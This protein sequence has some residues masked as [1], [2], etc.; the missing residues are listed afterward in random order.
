MKYFF[1]V[2]EAS[3]DV[4]ASKLLKEILIK[5][6]TAEV[7]FWGGDRMCEVAGADKMLSHY[8]DGAFMG[9]WEVIK[10]LFV[11]LNR[12]S[13]CKKDIIEFAPDVVVLV[14][15]AGFN[16]KIAKFAKSHKI[17]TYY[18][19]APKVWAWNEK[20]TKKI[21]KYVDELFCIFPFEIPFFKKWGIDAHYFGNPIMEEISAMSL[22]VPSYDRFIKDNDLES[23]PIIALLAGS[24][25]QE[26]ELNLPFMSL[27]A[28]E[29]PDHQFVVAAVDWLDKSLYER[30]VSTNAKNIKIV[31]NKTY[32]TLLNSQAAIVTSGTATLETALLRV[33]EVVCY[34]CSPISYHIARMVVRIKFISLVNIVLDRLVVKEFINNDMTIQN[35]KNELID[36]LPCGSRNKSLLSDYDVLLSKMGGADTSEKVAD[37]MIK[38]L[39]GQRDENI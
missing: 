18:Y 22:N 37:K 36:I 15:F 34:K 25:K 10:N 19:I 5:D 8:R 7:R 17:K 9:F 32:E 21:S 6:P 14:D 33:P 26:V 23:K 12:I 13:R 38:L 11:I 4:H 31:Y 20:R 29:F 27:V 30:I 35:V 16:M 2:G 1:V 28:A 3:G 39:K 24:R